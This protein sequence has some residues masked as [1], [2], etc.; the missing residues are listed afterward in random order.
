RSS[1]SFRTCSSLL[2]LNAPR[3]RGKPH[4]RGDHFRV[5][6]DCRDDI[7]S[8]GAMRGDGDDGRRA[9]AVAPGMAG[10]ALDDGIAGAQDDLL[11]V[12]DEDDLALENKAE[13]DRRRLL[14]IEMRAGDGG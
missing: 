14:H 6:P 12:E 9:R 8:G 5:W 7:P 3:E 4:E 13:I 2:P 11:A 1:H 10:A